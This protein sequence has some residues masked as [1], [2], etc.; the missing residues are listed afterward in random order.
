MLAGAVGLIMPARD[1]CWGNGRTNACWKA[2]NASWQV[3]AAD[4]RDACWNDTVMLA[5]AVRLPIQAGRVGLLMLVMLAG[6]MALLMLAG[7]LGRLM[8]VM[9]AGAVGLPIQAGKFGRLMLLMR[10]VAVAGSSG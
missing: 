8:L 10:A 6:A 9:L 5:G 2:T 4:A 1:A 7:R 3:W